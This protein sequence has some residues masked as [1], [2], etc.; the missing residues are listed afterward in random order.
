MTTEKKY[1]PSL[2]GAFSNEAFAKNGEDGIL[3]NVTE[4]NYD[5]I[6]KNLSIGSSILLRFNK[7]TAKGNKHY[8]TEILPPYDKTKAA[9]KRAT[10]TSE[11]D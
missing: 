4:E 6:M 9:A 1:N 11:L 5:V 3:I 10:T 2:G 8:F 7:V